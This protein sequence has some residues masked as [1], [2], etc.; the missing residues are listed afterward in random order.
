MH[1]QCTALRQD[2]SSIWVFSNINNL[3]LDTFLLIKDESE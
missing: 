3:Y 2:M 1:I